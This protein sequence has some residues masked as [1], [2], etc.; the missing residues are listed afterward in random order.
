MAYTVVMKTPSDRTFIKTPIQAPI[1]TLVKSIRDHSTEVLVH[2]VFWLLVILLSETIKVSTDVFH[3]DKLYPN[4]IFIGSAFN[5]L[6]F[7]LN[8]LWLIPRYMSQRAGF[9]A[10][11]FVLLIGSSAVIE[12]LIDSQLIAVMPDLPDLEPM[13]SLLTINTTLHMMFGLVSSL[14]RLRRD[15]YVSQKVQKAIKAQHTQTELDLL[16]SQV[17]PHFLFNTL[18]TLYSSAYEHGDE[19][20]ANGIGKLSHLLRYMLYETKDEQVALENEVDYLQDYID[21]QKMRFSND[22]DITFNIQ[23]DTDNITVAPMLF[24]TLIENAFKH[25]ISTAKHSTI[26]IEIAIS[27]NNIV[28][29]VENDIHPQ[30]A[31]TAL[32]GDAGGLGLDNLKRRLSLL[33]PQ[34][35]ELTIMPDNNNNRFNTRLELR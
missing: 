28:L 14:I 32:E 17:H 35:H 27:A 5:L 4:H 12:S 7:Y 6:V 3:S 19:E 26:A 29:S 33:Y 21:L 15:S 24:I 23:G 10:L 18:N 25:G 20:T 16:K 9:Y 13:L 2:L 34:R 22:V 8:Y 1:Q 31:K 30:R 11:S